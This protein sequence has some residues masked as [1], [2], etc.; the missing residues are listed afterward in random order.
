MSVMTSRTR[1][2]IQGQ[3]EVAQQL[4]GPAAAD[5]MA[6]LRMELKAFRQVILMGTGASLL[7]CRAAQYAFMK[8]GGALPLV[9]PAAEIDYVLPAAGPQTLVVLVSQSGQSYETQVAVRLL[10][11]RG[12]RFWG[13]TNSPDSVLAA[14]AD[15]VLLMEAGEE[16]SSATKTYT[17]TLLLFYRLA[18]VPEQ[19]LAAVP[20][21]IERSL[22]AADP[23]IARWA[24][25]LQGRA[26][27]YTL[28]MGSLGVAA[29]A[30]A[31]LLKE[32]TA[33]PVEGMSL[34]EFRHG[35]IE[36]VRPGLPILLA[37]ATPA[38]AGDVLKHGE[39]F[40]SLGAEV[41]L[42][43]DTPLTSSRIPAEQIL[44]V[45]NRG[46]EIT[47][48]MPAVIPFQLLAERIAAITGRDVDGF[49]Y[50]AKTV[51]TYKL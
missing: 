17:A 7:A 38:A 9:V 5:R 10:K 32:K 16:V 19:L 41:Y 24:E 20:G 39:Y 42:V 35:H 3:V 2:E 37:A 27:I 11:E 25:A 23:V 26:V 28:G 47:G 34:S 36:V 8:Y 33:I 45:A 46:D 51:D 49:R 18:G 30:G 4:T 15:R 12:V 40:A 13:I 44:I 43:T 48:Q 6:A 50:I 21:D 14:Q 1:Q 31:L 22:A 29:G